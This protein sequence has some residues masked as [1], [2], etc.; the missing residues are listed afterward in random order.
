MELSLHFKLVAVEDHERLN[1]E[2]GETDPKNPDVIQLNFDEL[3]KHAD[4]GLR[5]EGTLIHE[6]IH[7]YFYRTHPGEEM[8]AME[9]IALLGEFLYDLK[10]FGKEATFLSFQPLL[11]EY[12]K[13]SKRS[14]NSF[15]QT[16]AD[17]GKTFLFYLFAYETFQRDDFVRTY[18]RNQRVGINSV[19]EAIQ[20]NPQSRFTPDAW[21]NESVIVTQFYQS[22]INRRN[23]LGISLND[24]FTQM[25]AQSKVAQNPSL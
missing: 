19:I 9:G 13:S 10:Y 4:N 21:K 1:R 20:L 18:F 5:E 14:L 3:R 15:D 23:T 25:L 16:A 12:F 2:Y 6:A 8:W 24:L 17:Y 11:N 22:L 7:L